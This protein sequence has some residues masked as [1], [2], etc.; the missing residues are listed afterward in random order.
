MRISTLSFLTLAG[1]SLAACAPTYSNTR[2]PS[3]DGGRAAM[4]AITGAV[5][6]DV[7]DKNAITGAA[8][9]A[10]AGALADDAGV[11]N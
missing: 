10:T 1:L 3:G 7:F 11:C 2:C 5:L 9:G 6:A 8:I 4:G